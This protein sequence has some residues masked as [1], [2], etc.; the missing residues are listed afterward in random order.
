MSVRE[1]AIRF[2]T[3]YG[4]IYNRL[5]RRVVMRPSG[6][7]RRRKDPV[8]TAVAIRERIID[9]E[10][11]P[12]RRI[13]SQVELAATFQ[14]SHREIAQAVVHLRQQGYVNPVRHEGTFVLPEQC[15]GHGT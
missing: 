3:S 15:W 9:G 5:C 14:V 6:D 11:K 10:W 4:K 8:K 2:N 7:R 12:G 13:P 1:I